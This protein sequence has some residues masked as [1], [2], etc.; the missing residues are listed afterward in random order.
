VCENLRADK[1]IKVVAVVSF[2]QQLS[3]SR[4]FPL[5]LT[6]SNS[7]LQKMRLWMSVFKER[8]RVG[9]CSYFLSEVDSLICK[10]LRPGTRTCV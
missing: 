3:L 9:R 8:E 10:K 4:L 2:I 5:G 6:R 1:K 7:R